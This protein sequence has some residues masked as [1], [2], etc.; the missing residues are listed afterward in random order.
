MIPRT[1]WRDVRACQ[2]TPHV[3]QNIHA[4]RPRSAINGRTTSHTGYDE[5]Q[6]KRKLVEEGF[7]WGK[8]IGGLGKLHH[9]GLERVHWIFTLTNAVLT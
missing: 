2:T 7:G 4:R 1:S 9:R 5:S 8:V 6:R 3:A